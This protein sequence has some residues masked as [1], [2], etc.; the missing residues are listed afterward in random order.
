MDDPHPGPVTPGRL[1]PILDPD[2]V[3]MVR[4]IL[5]VREAGGVPLVG[6]AHWD[7]AF[8]QRTAATA[9]ALRPA[10]HIAWATFSSGSTGAPR[11]I[12]RSAESW[13]SSFPA[14]TEAMEL[15]PGDAVLLPAPLASSLSLFSLAHARASGA[16][17]LLPRGRTVAGRDLEGA[18]IVHCTPPALATIVTA[19]EG[20]APHGLRTALVGG[21]RLDPALRSRAEALGVRAVSYYGAA[22]LSF[23][24]IDRDGSGLRPFPGVELRVIDDELWVRSPFLADGYLGESRGALRRDAGGWATVGDRAE[25]D[26][27]GRVRL[28]GRSDGAILTAA[29]TVI[30]DDVE[31]ALLTIPGIAEAVVFAFPAP[32]DDSIVAAVVRFDG[33]PPP[34]LRARAAALLS[35][36]HLPRLWFTVAELPT[37]ASG[38]PAR[39]R[40]R[41]DAIAGRMARLG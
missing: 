28:L 6:D 16:G 33:A 10:P 39:A 5:A 26:A 40:I 13:E 7:R 8:W 24:A 11:I 12:A 23:V 35:S 30:P 34:E 3:A 27:S 9:A 20:G 29:A 14:V 4:T 21:A 15:H 22:E 17:I 18:T 36:S 1:V 32:G 41:D 19:I 2:P 25:V 31:A 37:T 38:K